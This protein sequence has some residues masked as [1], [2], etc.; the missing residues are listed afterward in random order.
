MYAQ[1][2][3]QAHAPLTHSRRHPRVPV[4]QPC[5]VN[6][7]DRST[8]AHLCDISY[9]GARI[10][11]PMVASIYQMHRLTSVHAP[12]IG[13]VRVQLRWHSDRE[14]GVEFVAPQ[15]VRQAVARIMATADPRSRI[16]PIG[17]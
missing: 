15:T 10:A 14:I 9:G 3:I 16:R 2:H 12:Q 1:P 4:D 17:G 6:F 13:L 7:A 8:R 11:L 5:T